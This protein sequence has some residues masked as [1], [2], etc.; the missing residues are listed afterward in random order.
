MIDKRPFK[1]QR[2][3]DSKQCNRCGRHNHQTPQC[4]ATYNINNEYLGKVNTNNNDKY[5]KRCWR[6]NH[7][8]H[9]CKARF[10][11]NKAPI[12]DNKI[13]SFDKRNTNTNTKNIQTKSQLLTLENDPANNNTTSTTDFQRNVSLMSQS[14]N[15]NDQ[16]NPQQQFQ[17]Q[18]LLNQL[19][20]V[21]NQRPLQR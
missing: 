14:I 4:V 2:Y 11:P 7:Y 8:T 6:N 3:N 20:S 18:T 10:Y 15:K 12:T 1:K 16:I 21:I 13:S 19:N 9:E 5:C 17:C